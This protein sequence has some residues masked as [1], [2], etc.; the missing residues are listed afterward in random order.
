MEDE[1]RRR[2]AKFELFEAGRGSLGDTRLFEDRVVL[3]E[4]G[5]ESVRLIET[6]AWALSSSA[7]ALAASCLVDSIRTF[8]GLIGNAPAMPE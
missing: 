5:R 3:N 4:D 1:R 2:N 8:R 6:S 7:C